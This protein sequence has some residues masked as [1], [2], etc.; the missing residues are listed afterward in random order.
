[1]CKTETSHLNSL[2]ISGRQMR[3]GEVQFSLWDMSYNLKLCS[4]E[5]S[6]EHLDLVAHVLLNKVYCEMM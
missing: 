5:F 3:K 1:M 6:G 4:S 2:T